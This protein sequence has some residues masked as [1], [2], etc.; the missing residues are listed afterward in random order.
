M[1]GVLAFWNFEIG[2][3]QRA[4][5]GVFAA[6]LRPIN[7]PFVRVERDAHAPV[8]RI[9]AIFLAMAGFDQRFQLRAVQI[10]SHHPHSFAIGPVQLPVLPVDL[11]LLR[12]ERAADRYD[13]GEAGAVQ[14][15]ALH[16]TVVELHLAHVAPENM[17][18]RGVDGYAVRTL[19]EAVLKHFQIGAVGIG[20]EPGA[21]RDI[22][23]EDPPLGGR[24][25]RRAPESHDRQQR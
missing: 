11:E 20:R 18:R 1:R 8:P 19:P 15:D 5:V 3:A 6:L 24:V 16:R 14:V 4:L 12:G 21:R 2:A 17:A 22:E 13:G 25:V 10:R 23:K 9:L 7:L